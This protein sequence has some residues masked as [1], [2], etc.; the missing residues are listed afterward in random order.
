MAAFLISLFA[1]AAKLLDDPARFVALFFLAG[2]TFVR[3]YRMLFPSQPPENRVFRWRI[4][5]ALLLFFFSAGLI[6]LAI[7]HLSFE[8]SPVR[9]GFQAEPTLATVVGDVFW[10]SGSFLLLLGAATLWNRKWWATLLALL[11]GVVLLYSAQLL[12]GFRLFNEFSLR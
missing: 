7:A 1:A 9:V 3:L 6:E 8:H 5:P 10:M 4:I 2:L 12:G 11:L